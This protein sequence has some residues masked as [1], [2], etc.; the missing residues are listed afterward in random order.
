MVVQKVDSSMFQRLRVLS[1]LEGVLVHSFCLFEIPILDVLDFF[2]LFPNL[3]K[4]ESLAQTH[5]LKDLN[6]SFLTFSDA[7]FGEFVAASGHSCSVSFDKCKPVSVS[8]RFSA[9][10]AHVYEIAS[11]PK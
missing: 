5:R 8:D 2:L 4:R 10:N 6:Q 3:Y 7:S 11:H 1:E 9:H